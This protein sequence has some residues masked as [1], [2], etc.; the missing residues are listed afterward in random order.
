MTNITSLT[1]DLAERS[2]PIH[3][4]TA[5]LER[6]P[7][8]VPLDLSGRKIFVLYDRNV[9]GHMRRL[10]ASLPGEVQIKA[11]DGGEPTKS[12]TRLECVLEWLLE[13]RVD[14]RSVLFVMGGGVVGD[15]GGFAA[16]IVLRGIPFVQVPTTLLAQVDSSVGG[17]T[18]INTAQGKNLVGSFYQPAAVLCDTDT[19]KTLPDRELKAGYAEV[20]KYALL[21]S[22]EFYDWLEVNGDKIL[23]LSDSELTDAIETSCRMKAEIVGDDEREQAGGDR[24]LLNLGHTF[25]H[26]LES[27]ARYDGRLLHGEAVSIGLVLAFRLC[28]K[29]GLCP[30]QDSVRMDR[31]LK[32]LGLKTEIS[33]IQPVLTHDA[34]EIAA[35]MSHDKKAAG[36][37]IGFI[38]VHEIGRAF[39][40]SD[41]DMAD[42]IAV[43]EDSFR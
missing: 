28:V 19:L 41:V 1:V 21:G 2:Y 20:V 27:A 10:I 40:S 23:A 39:Q 32:S 3:I 24:A 37:R 16:S 38:L 5:L 12:Y 29:M 17:K 7:D 43:I 30:G 22:R 4:G 13:N 6:A 14:R 36:G 25:A 35:M 26:A 31:H 42:V 18:G 11:V 33:E 34:R 8:F 15:L 9:E